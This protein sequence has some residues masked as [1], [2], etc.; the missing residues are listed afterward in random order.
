MTARDIV[1]AHLKGR[2]FLTPEV[3]EYVHIKRGLACELSRGGFM[4]TKLFGVTVVDS[5]LGQMSDL[6]DC[7][8]SEDEAR[9]YIES[10]K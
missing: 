6:S 10:L 3:I 5:M 7:F 4:D 9:A 2:N 1:T 8:S